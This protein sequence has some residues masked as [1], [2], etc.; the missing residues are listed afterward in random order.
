MVR[1]LFNPCATSEDINAI[2]KRTFFILF[3]KEKIYFRTPS[4]DPAAKVSAYTYWPEAEDKDLLAPSGIKKLKSY[5]S[6]DKTPPESDHDDRA[7][8]MAFM[9]RILHGEPVTLH[10]YTQ[11]IYDDQDIKIGCR[12]F[13]DKED[14]LRS[15]RKRGHQDMLPLDYVPGQAT[16]SG[17]RQDGMDLQ[18]HEP[19]NHHAD[20]SAAMEEPDN[21]ME[22]ELNDLM[23]AAPD[24]NEFLVNL[25]DEGIDG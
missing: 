1:P 2:P 12:Y 22:H 24:F 11:T 8:Q 15:S 21:D 7:W 20:T 5:R 19:V 9:K 3:G 10:Y 14:L 16:S 18:R 25:R 23:E 17:A 6:G 13:D 4:A